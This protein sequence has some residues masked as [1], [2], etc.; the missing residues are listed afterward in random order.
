[1]YIYLGVLAI[2]LINGLMLGHKRKWFVFSS[3]FLLILLAALRKYTVGIDLGLHYANNHTVIAKLPWSKIIQYYEESTYDLGFVIFV[4]ILGMISEN[5]QIFIIVTSVVVYG[6]NARYI[7]RHSE[8]VVLETFLF[9]TSF[10]M[11]MYMNIIAQALAISV[12]LIGLDFLAEKKY[13]KYVVCVLLATTIHTSAII[14]IVFIPLTTLSNSRKNIIRYIL[15]VGIGSLCLDR[16][17]S[18]LIKTVFSEFSVYFETDSYHGEGINISA[19]SLFQISMHLIAAIIAV[20]FLN[21]N[22]MFKE[23]ALRLYRRKK[24]SRFGRRKV[25]C[26]IVQLPTS[27][28]MYMSITA[29]VFRIIVYQS[30]IFSR[31]GFYFYFFSF[32]LLA[33]GISKIENSEHRKMILSSIYIYMA[34]MFFV[35]YQAAGV[36]SYGV[37]PYMFFWQ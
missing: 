13:W 18:I 35:F 28:L 19:N 14:C 15:L 8:D 27:F 31:M 23:S 6:I 7:Y 29:C 12:I 24:T 10:T 20:S 34:A 21:N 16:V 5:S 9:I 30:Y 11:M 22:G 3:F 36:K 26:Q 1:M 4:R 2:I 37:L 33:R 25:P 32:S 17:L